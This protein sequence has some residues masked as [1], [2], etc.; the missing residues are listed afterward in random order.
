MHTSRCLTDR[1]GAA[2]NAE[3]GKQDELRLA[4]AEML[5]DV[6]AKVDILG[7]V[8]GL[9]RA[10]VRKPKASRAQSKT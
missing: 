4:Q 10:T 5:I 8:A 6:E 9:R 3:T 2:D 1:E 7:T